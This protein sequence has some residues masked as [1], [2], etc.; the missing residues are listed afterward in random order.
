MDIG[1]CDGPLEHPVTTLARMTWAPRCDSPAEVAA[2][3][4][5]SVKRVRRQ[6]ESGAMPS[7]RVGRRVLV[8]YRDADQLVRRNP[9]MAIAPGTETINPATGK[10]RPLSIEE[11]R[12]RSEAL[13][14]RPRGDRRHR[15]RD[16]QR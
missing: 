12:A 9:N 1:A 2:F 16:R 11:R 13:R 6:V 4:G 8:L 7:Y 15:R 3:L 14:P 10:A 5:V